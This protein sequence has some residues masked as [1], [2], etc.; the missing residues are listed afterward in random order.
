[1]SQ[2]LYSIG[3]NQTATLRMVAEL[4]KAVCYHCYHGNVP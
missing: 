1:M 3:M 2:V 4:M